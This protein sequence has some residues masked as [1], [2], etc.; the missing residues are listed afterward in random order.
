MISEERIWDIL[1]KYF[2]SE[3]FVGHQLESFN[4]FIIDGITRVLEE[5]PDIVINQDNS[6]YTVS[7]KNVHIPCPTVIEENRVLKT[8]LLPSETRQRDLTYDSPIYVDIIEKYEETGKEPELNIFRR[9]V[10]GRVPIMLRSI[11]CHLYNRTLEERIKLGECKYDHGGYFI[12]NGKER[13]LV[14]QV[15]SVYNK[16][17]VFSQKPDDKFEYVAE[18]RSMSQETGHS[19]LVKAMIGRNKRTM[20]L[21]PPYIKELIPFGV[22][23][24]ALGIINPNEIKKIIGNNFEQL[25]KYIKYIIRDSEFVTTQNEA[26][27]YIG[28]FSVHIIPVANRR[29][30]ALQVVQ[31]ELFPHMGITST[32]KEK[33]LFLGHIIN[34]LLLTH[35]GIRGEDDKDHYKNKRVESSGILCY[36]LFKTLFKRY[37]SVIVQYLE[38]KKQR[39]DVLSV[40][41]RINSITTGLRYSFA[42]GNWGVQKNSYQRLGVSQVLSRLS[43]GA[44]LSHLRRIMLQ[45]GKEGKNS[46]IR[47][48]NPSQIMFICPAETP[49]GQPVGTV[50]NLSLLAKISKRT[51]SILIREVI[52]SLES[53]KFIKDYNFD[54]FEAK[55][56]LNGMLMG[57]TN[58]AYKII[59]ELKKYRESKMIPDEVSIS[60]DDLD[61]EIHIYSDEGRLIRPVFNVKDSKLVLTNNDCTDWNSLVEKGIIKYID[62]SEIDNCVIAFNQEELTK[63]HNDYCEISATM[64][65][66]VMASII[67]FPD[68]SQSPRNCY[69]A[70]MGKQAMS[71]FSLSH[72]LR[73]DTITHIIG[74]PQKPLVSTKPANMMGFN[75][76]P[77]GINAIVAIATYTG[78]N[79]EDSVIMNKS[80]IDRGLF[81]SYA[82]RTYTQEEKKQGTYNFE[83]IGCLP[84]N[85]QRSDVNYNMLG[86]NG[87]VRIGSHVGKN[88]VIIGKIFVKSNKCGEEE[89]SDCSLV[90]KKGE[91]GIV[92]RIFDTITPNGYRLVKVVIRTLK[93]PEVGDKVASRSAQ[94]GTIGMVFKQEDMPF[95]NCGII[96]DIII[97]P[98]CIPS[99]MTVNQLMECILGKAC[100]MDGEF[101]DSTPFTSSSIDVSKKLC[102]KLGKT[103]FERHGYEQLFNGMT[104]EPIKAK[105]FIGPTYYQRLK[106]LVSDKIHARASGYVTTLTRQPLEGRSRDGG[107]RFGEMERDCMIAHGVSR[108]LKERLFD[109]SDPYQIAICDICGNFSTT[110]K[111]CKGCKSDQISKVNMPYASKLLIQELNAM[112]LK[113]MIKSKS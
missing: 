93:I 57:I 39:P 6:K 53:I 26:L 64:M 46:K 109:Q 99:R 89:I 12:I 78:F 105:I 23:F 10:I 14:S 20:V 85:K 49:E 59:E 71:M 81:W 27:D 102:E 91:E 25:E 19:V 44:T 65:L 62:N 96:P 74:Y 16:V 33:A 48:I 84:L 42:T 104:G 55:I 90:L 108:F 100:I 1:G 98:H 4:S 82:Y 86:K 80:S 67:P 15:R 87:I 101:G 5:E 61:G 24:K 58:D 47:Q 66:G 79:Q 40:I 30:Y 107:L 3:G 29:D 75:D 43:Y 112:G 70:A 22:I 97:N 28:K 95:T 51:P 13:V 83:R 77:S 106:H 31:T 45:I 35:L 11:R 88:D 52:E 113:T 76:M 94:K 60:Y 21:S 68:H 36:E 92:D 7:F 110:Q 18:I 50:L 111:E 17:M 72:L 8:V 54:D 41:S 63:Y 56:F 69:Q 73:A 103:G 9:R 34:K 37:N 32:N 2:K 38:K